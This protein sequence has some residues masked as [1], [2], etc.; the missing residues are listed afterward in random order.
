MLIEKS[1]G[2]VPHSGGAKLTKGDE[3][4]NSL[5]RWHE[6]GAP[7]DAATVAEPISMEVYPKS[8]VLDGKGSKQRLNVRAKYSDGT[9]RDVTSLALF[10]TNNDNSAKIDPTGAVTAS[11]R[12]EAFVMARF[13]TFTIGSPVIVLPQGLQFTFPQVPENNYV[14]TLINKKLRNLRITP[15]EL[16]TDEVF[17]RRLYIDICGVLPTA[18]EY[19][20]S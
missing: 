17:L 11:E 9:D 18:E 3:Y 8:A 7:L 13:A 5:I 12:G 10:L 14:D 1:T 16:C 6:A 19:T 2:A 4:Y 20:A 15:S